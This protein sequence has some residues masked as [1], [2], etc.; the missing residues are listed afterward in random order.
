[1][2]DVWFGFEVFY[3]YFILQQKKLALLHTG[4]KGHI[5]ELLPCG[6][7]IVEVAIRFEFHPVHPGVV[8]PVV[9]SRGD[10]HLVAHRDGVS[11]CSL[12]KQTREQVQSAEVVC[13]YT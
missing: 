6:R 3:V 10:A 1:M 12:R 7:I 5:G 2:T 9:N 13:A 11:C 4:S 8:E